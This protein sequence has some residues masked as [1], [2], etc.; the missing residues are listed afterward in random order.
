MIKAINR[1]DFDSLT[2]QIFFL[3]I[4]RC[5]VIREC[6]SCCACGKSCVPAAEYEILHR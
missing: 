3:R 5:E 1:K 4:S 6:Q 2:I